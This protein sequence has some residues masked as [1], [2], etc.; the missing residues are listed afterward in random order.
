MPHS[1]PLQ[2]ALVVARATAL[3]ATAS[4]CLA[5]C[6]VLAIATEQHTQV[7]YPT[8]AGTHVASVVPAFIPRDAKDV[9]VRSL[10]G[11]G[12][13]LRFDSTTPLDST[14][15]RAGELSGRPH[16]NSNWW[17]TS[18]P[19]AAGQVCGAGWQLF[20]VDGTTYGWTAK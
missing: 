15:C 8:L 19:P 3:L 12:R 6:S 2:R 18:K 17:P 16:M 1:I 10:A 11:H 5:G 7:F 4:L 14:L 13:T 20:E 9:T